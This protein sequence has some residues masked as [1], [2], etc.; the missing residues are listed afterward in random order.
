MGESRGG[1]PVAPSQ[2]SPGLERLQASPQASPQALDQEAA[3]WRNTAG[4]GAAGTELSGAW[5]R[6]L[7]PLLCPHRHPSLLHQILMADET[8]RPAADLKSVRCSPSF[9]LLI[10]TKGFVASCC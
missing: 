3:V 4:S 8:P 7:E 9:P 5:E 6:S 2:G 10:T 1:D